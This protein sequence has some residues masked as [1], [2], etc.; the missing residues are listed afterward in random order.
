VEREQLCPV[1]GRNDRYRIVARI[2]DITALPAAERMWGRSGTASGRVP[3]PSSH[4][5]REGL[6]GFRTSIARCLLGQP[7]KRFS[8]GRK[9]ACR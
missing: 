5:T 3:P 8:V 4:F 6:E 2:C 9:R 1:A 7:P